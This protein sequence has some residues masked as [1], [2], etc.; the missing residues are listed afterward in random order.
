MEGHVFVNPVD[1]NGSY[2][3]MLCFKNG[4]LNRE[5][6]REAIGSGS[7]DEFNKLLASTEPGNGGSI[8]LYVAESEITPPLPRGDYRFNGSQEAVESFDAATEARAL[9]EGMDLSMR[10]NPN[11]KL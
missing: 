5:R 1:P 9:V 3:V 6:V 2:M 10:P 11:P 7:W 8:G 4:S